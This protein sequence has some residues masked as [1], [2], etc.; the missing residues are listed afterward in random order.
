MSTVSR[1]RR[2]RTL[3]CIAL[4]PPAGS[5]HRPAADEVTLYTTRE[6]GLIQ[7]LIT[8]FSRKAASRST[9]CS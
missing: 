9:P 8:A 3:A 1:A 6:P 4:P 5:P 2:A 7:P